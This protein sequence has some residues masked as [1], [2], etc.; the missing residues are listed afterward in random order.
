MHNNFERSATE[1][2]APLYDASA[3]A[4]YCDAYAALYPSLYLA[5]WRLKHDLNVKNLAQLMQSLKTPVPAWLDLACGQ[6]W[7][8]SMFSGQ[9]RM[10]GLDLSAAQ[11]A[12]AKRR[13]PTA[14]FV[15]MDMARASFPEGSFDLVTNFWAA[16]CYLASE[17][18]IALVLRRALSWI[19]SA[20]ALYIEVLL[21]QDLERFNSSQFAGKTG[22]AVIPRSADYTDWRYED[23]GG[24]HEMI[25][26]SLEFFLDIIGPS[27]STIKARH[28]SAFMVH[29][30]ATNKKRG[31]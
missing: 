28:D 5:P 22:F 14:A 17:E 30:I 20:G 2:E 6:A 18:R 27:F 19:R 7:H 4:I 1:D 23:L 25:S 12:R 13:V 24:T 11:L 16:Y 15:Q 29:V 10:V 3:A 9:A 31:S 21:A 8:F 26:P